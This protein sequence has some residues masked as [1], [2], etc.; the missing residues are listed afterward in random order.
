MSIIV[1]AI[2]PL[3]LCINLPKSIKKKKMNNGAAKTQKA[4]EVIVSPANRVGNMVVKLI[5]PLIY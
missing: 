1:V 4:I 3:Y 5:N 2:I